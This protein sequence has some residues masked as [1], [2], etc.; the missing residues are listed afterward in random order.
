LKPNFARISKYTFHY[1]LRAAFFEGI[2]TGVWLLNDIVAR[3]H[4]LSSPFLLTLLVMAPSASLI[5]SLPLGPLMAVK[6]RKYFFLVAGAFRLSFLL[7]PFCRS[8][9]SFVILT[10]AAAI[11]Y[12]LFFTSQ[13]VILKEN[14]GEGVRGRLFGIVYSFSGLI[15]I[16]TSLSAGRLY[17]AFPFA[18]SI[19]YPAGALAGML[20]CVVLSRIK[21]RRKSAGE[22]IQ[23]LV[24]PLEILRKRPDFRQFE[25]SYFLYG[26]GFMMMLP[27][28]PLY[29]VDHLKVT[30]SQASFLNGLFYQGMIVIFS[31]FMG[32]SM[33][34]VH[35]L[36]LNRIGF[37]GLIFYPL[38]LAL[39]TTVIFAYPSYAWYGLSMAVVNVSWYL[40]PL[41]F[42]NIREEASSFMALHVALAGVRAF[43]AFPLGTLLYSL[44]GTFTIPFLV[45]SFL[46][47]LGAL[48]LPGPQKILKMSA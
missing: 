9:F 45:A 25:I 12:P 41:T 21:G 46:F 15:A 19:V 11:S 2:F 47:L 36:H 24:K 39:A 30:Y 26:I 29:L 16:I 14:Y 42:C 34:R 43:I 35:P 8:A 32:R 18:P 20:S 3:K 37:Y 28:L 1:H 17:D 6:P 44:T 48:I 22:M 27:L 31:W 40:T 7:V 13:N 38:S 23:P 5:L 10:S 33:D 4:F